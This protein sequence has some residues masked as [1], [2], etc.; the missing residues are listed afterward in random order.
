MNIQQIRTH[1]KQ[2]GLEAY[3]VAHGN[4]FI[5]EDIKTAEHKLKQICGFSGSAGILAITA[6]KCYLL[7]DGRYELQ[8][9]LETNAEEVEVVDMM[10]RLKNVCD[11]LSSYHIYSVGYDSWNHS[12][13][14]MEFIKRRYKDMQ[15]TDIGDLVTTAANISPI[16]VRQRDV[17]FA[18]LSREQKCRYITDMLAEK[19]A[20]YCLIT[21]ADSVSWLLN[22]YAEDLPYSPIVRAYALISATGDITLFG[23]NL[24]ADLPTENWDKFAQKMAALD[25]AKIMY[26]PHNTPEKIK[27]L[28]SAETVLIKTPDICQTLKAEKNPTEIRG[29]I[30]CHIRDGVAL[31]KFLCW[32]EQ[33]YQGLSELDVVEKLHEFRSQQENFFSESFA[34]IAGSAENGAIVHYQPNHKSN[35]R[36][37]DNNLLLIDSGGQYLDGTTDV[38]RTIALGTPSAEMIKDFTLVLKA[39]ISLAQARFPV[40][41]AG[42]KLDIVAR[43]C[44]WQEG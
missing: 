22:I 36:L 25:N 37:A 43:G 12:V 30:N 6:D 5:G 42:T 34:T 39:H 11:L 16:I 20:D 8:A 41:T 17:K 31:S 38:T 19:S 33:H 1:I 40:D 24:K 35:R 29:M 2:M 10:P 7:V 3:V 23:N 18:G 26:D 4:R 32:L 15:F 28:I 44:L 21:A 14:E 13:A 9:R 27:S